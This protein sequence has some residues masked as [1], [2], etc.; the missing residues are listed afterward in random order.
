MSLDLAPLPQPTL[1]DLSPDLLAELAP[2]LVLARSEPTHGLVS[3]G[4]GVSKGFR[5]SRPLLDPGSDPLGG[6]PVWEP[7]SR[8]WL[9][10]NW[11]D[12]PLKAWA[13]ERA[14]NG[15]QTLE[16]VHI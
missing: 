14:G 5:P 12:V 11:E 3:W 16:K 7:S 15:Q 1:D 9:I 13:E 2:H 6:D 10:K 8:Y 4:H